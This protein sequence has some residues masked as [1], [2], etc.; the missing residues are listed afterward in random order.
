MSS[1]TAPGEP[2]SRLIF[3]Y[4]VQSSP[5][6]GREDAQL[7]FLN[8][9]KKQA[10]FPLER[11]RCTWCTPNLHSRE[12]S[13]LIF[14]NLEKMQAD[15]PLE[16]RRRTWCTPSPHSREDSQLVFLNLEKKQADFPL[17]RRRRT[18]CTPSLDRG[19]DAQLIFQ[20]KGLTDFLRPLIPHLPLP[21]QHQMFRHLNRDKS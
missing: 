10:D 6:Y 20:I 12:D 14:L 3:N 9:E 7:V 11:R 1:P 8:L 21:L 2:H 19:E 15:F 18:W 13:P 16:R 5:Q 17:E 4:F